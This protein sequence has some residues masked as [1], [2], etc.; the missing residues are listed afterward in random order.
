MKFQICWRSKTTNKSGQGKA[1]ES[2]RAAAQGIVDE[3]NKKYPTVF[4]WLVEA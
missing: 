4:H 2:T 3:L 1:F